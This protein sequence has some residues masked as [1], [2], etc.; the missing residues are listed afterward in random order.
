M[1]FDSSNTVERVTEVQ[2]SKVKNG[3]N[4]S[5]QIMSRV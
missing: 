3:M 2:L 1:E 4:I 5:D